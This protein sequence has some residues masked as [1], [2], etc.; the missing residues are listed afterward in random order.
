VFGSV[1]PK[2]ALSLP[3][4]SGGSQRRFCSALPK[5]TTGCRPKMFMCTADAPDR[6]AP[7]AEMVCIIKA[8][9]LMPRPAPPYSSGIAM[10]SQ[11]ESAS[12]R[13]KSCGNPPS[14][15]LRSQ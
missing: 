14:R 13:W 8:A 12:A 3:S 9:S 2:Q 15:S 4:I 1:T 7:V 5:T 10:P 11:P 6:P